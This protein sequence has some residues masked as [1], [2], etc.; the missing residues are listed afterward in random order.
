MDN[1][2]GHF[3]EGRHF[4]RMDEDSLLVHEKFIQLFE[5]QS[6][7]FRPL[8]GFRERNDENSQLIE[9]NTRHDGSPGRHCHYPDSDPVLGMPKRVDLHEM[10]QSTRQDKNP[11]TKDDGTKLELDLSDQ[12]QKGDGYRD[13]RTSDQKIGHHHVPNERL[14]I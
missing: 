4:R 12:N 2:S 1:P 14:L 11:E 10:S 6:P 9:V 13:I 3:A 8:H 7:L 5:L